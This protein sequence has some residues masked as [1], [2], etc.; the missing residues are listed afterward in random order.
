M[1]HVFYFEFVLSVS[2]TDSVAIQ[3]RCEVCVVADIEPD[4]TIKSD[5][6][7]HK[8]WLR[9]DRLNDVE[10]PFGSPLFRQAMRWFADKETGRVDDAWSGQFKPEKL[11]Y[12][13]LR[14]EFL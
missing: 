10:I 9:R 4:T 2:I 3:P 6:N 7:I 13:H 1:E 8:F 12:G 14:H 11:G 5:W